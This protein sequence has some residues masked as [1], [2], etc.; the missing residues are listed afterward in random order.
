MGIEKEL[1]ALGC[2]PY[3]HNRVIG[4]DNK[5][6]RYTL[7]KTGLSVEIHWTILAPSYP[8]QIDVEGLWTRAQPV[9]LAQFPA[10]ALSPEE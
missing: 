4:Q 3:D 9:T 7:P 2:K 10:L 1:L 6:F 5:H 8:F